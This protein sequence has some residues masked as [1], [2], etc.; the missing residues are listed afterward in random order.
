MNMPMAD[1]YRSAEKKPQHS[2]IAMQHGPA[3][4]RKLVYAVSSKDW[5]DLL[6][7]EVVLAEDQQAALSDVLATMGVP[8]NKFLGYL[9]PRNI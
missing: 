4:P 2:S 5:L 9:L 7:P 1:D 8:M 3:S 6:A